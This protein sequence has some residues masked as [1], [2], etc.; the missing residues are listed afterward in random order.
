MLKPIAHGYRRGIPQFSLCS[1][2]AVVVV[3]S[4]EGHSHGGEGWLESEERGEEEDEE[5]EEPGYKVEEPVGEVGGGG[6][7]PQPRQNLGQELPKWQRVVIGNVV[8]L[9]RGSCKFFQPR[10]GALG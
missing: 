2:A 6:G 3:C 9:E 7:V 5:L 8:G 1:P 4:S 10:E